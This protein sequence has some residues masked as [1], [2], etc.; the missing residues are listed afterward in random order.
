MG[1][2]YLLQD[3]WGYM[4]KQGVIL[5]TTPVS[6]SDLELPQNNH[7]KEVSTEPAVAARKS[8]SLGN[9]FAKSNALRKLFQLT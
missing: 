2:I 9:Y 4:R 8:N 7:Q 1:L 6:P 5:G 3:K